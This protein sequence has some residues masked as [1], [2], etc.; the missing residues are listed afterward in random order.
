MKTLNY[1]DIVST[2]KFKIGFIY[3]RRLLKHIE[4]FMLGIIK[5]NAAII[6]IILC[7]TRIHLDW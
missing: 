5:I 2:F 4:C 7:Y 3:G 6:P 1:G